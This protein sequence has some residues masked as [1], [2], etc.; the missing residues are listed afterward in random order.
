MIALEL[1][2][3]H[4]ALLLYIIFIIILLLARP[5]FMFTYDG[6]LKKWGIEN[7]ENTNMFAFGFIVP[8]AGI[9]MYII[10]TWLDVVMYEP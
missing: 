9:V 8:L 2:R 5:S 3:L 1:T 7:D 6:R 4:V 10:A